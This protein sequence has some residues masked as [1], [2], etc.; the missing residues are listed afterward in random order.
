MRDSG[1]VFIVVWAA[2][3]YLDQRINCLQ[4]MPLP[5]DPGQETVSPPT[6]DSKTHEQHLQPSKILLLPRDLSPS[7]PI[8]LHH[9]KTTLQFP[10]NFGPTSS[11]SLKSLTGRGPAE[12]GILAFHALISSISTALLAPG[13]PSCADVPFGISPFSPPS[14]A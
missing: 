11:N 5:N 9:T 13:A 14:E 7:H 12:S 1:G 8:P 10:Y 4:G 6:P 2:L 3:V